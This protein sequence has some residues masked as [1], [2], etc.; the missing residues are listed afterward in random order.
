MNIIVLTLETILTFG[1]YKGEQ[2][3]DVIND[4]PEYFEWLYNKDI[5]R[6]DNETSSLLTKLK[7]I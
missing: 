3:E 1:K 4:H 6:F 5:V 2:V 7:V